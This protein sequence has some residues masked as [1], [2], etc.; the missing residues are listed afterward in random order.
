MGISRAL[1]TVEF[2]R[3]Y[4]FITAPIHKKCRSGHRKL[5][6]QNLSRFDFMGRIDKGINKTDADAF[7]SFLLGDFRN[8]SEILFIKRSHFSASIIYSLSN[9]MDVSSSNGRKLR[10]PV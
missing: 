6:F 10:F 7:D 3:S 8:L 1:I 9:G 4:S 2:V 5:A